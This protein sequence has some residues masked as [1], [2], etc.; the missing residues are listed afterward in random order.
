MA[1]LETSPQK[2]HPVSEKRLKC[3][4]GP[5]APPLH[6]VFKITLR[7]HVGLSW[8]L[9]A[10]FG[11]L[12]HLGGPNFLKDEEPCSLSWRR[13]KGSQAENHLLRGVQVRNE[14]PPMSSALPW[15]RFAQ[16]AA[17]CG[18][19]RC[20]IRG[21]PCAGR[22]RGGISSS[23]WSA[24]FLEAREVLGHEILRG[25]HLKRDGWTRKSPARCT[26]PAPTLGS[27]RSSVL[28]AG[29]FKGCKIFRS[30]PPGVPLN[31]PREAYPT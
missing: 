6:L 12:Q 23:A 1:F 25:N 14:E 24:H 29:R 5:G 30:V 18:T 10:P 15:R 13:L 28:S 31:Q 20:V 7:V 27:T 17:R 22:P 2:R 4:G 3:R 9:R 21:R 16:S 8:F 11:G 26:K 19:V